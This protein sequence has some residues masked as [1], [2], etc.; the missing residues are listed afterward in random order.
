MVLLFYGS[1]AH[2]YTSNDGRP[3]QR[4][5]TRDACRTNRS[6]LCSKGSVRTYEQNWQT[7]RGDR[8]II[9]RGF[10]NVAKGLI[11]ERRMSRRRQRLWHGTARDKNTLRS[12]NGKIKLSWNSCR[13]SSP[14]RGA[15]PGT[16]NFV[17]FHA[18]SFLSFASKVPFAPSWGS[19][20]PGCLAFPGGGYRCKS[21][22][23]CS[24]R[25]RAL[26]TAV[27]AISRV[28][29]SPGYRNATA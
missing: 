2:S 3:G 28:A 27:R 5:R 29:D 15:T 9:G 24:R 25:R 12:L 17:R 6:R 4:D 20:F 23:I 16:T 22:R 1:A 8:H 21:V 13:P 18:G 10:G 19:A 14:P 7:K 11:H 26:A